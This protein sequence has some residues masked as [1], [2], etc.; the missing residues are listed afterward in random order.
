MP[1]RSCLRDSALETI[2]SLEVEDGNYAIDLNLLQNRFDN[3]RLVFQTH[4][5]DILGLK[6]V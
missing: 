4:I 6:A 5:N 3:R 2:S 1:L